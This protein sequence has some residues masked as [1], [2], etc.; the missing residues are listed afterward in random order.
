MQVYEGQG[1]VSCGD[2]GTPIV[3]LIWPTD[4]LGIETILLMR[5][6][7]KTRNWLP[8]E[9]MTDLLVENAAHGIFPRGLTGAESG[10]LM[11]TIDGRISGGLVG[12]QL[13][14]DT[15]RHQ[16]ESGAYGLD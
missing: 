2:C 1:F 16:I 12:L 4:P 8:G 3:E 14:S 11:Q 6:A 5:P 13:T 7:E 9:T 15:R 10:L